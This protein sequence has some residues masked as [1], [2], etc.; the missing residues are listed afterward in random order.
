MY[1]VSVARSL[2]KIEASDKDPCSSVFQMDGFI[3]D[4][5]YVAKKITMVLYINGM[6]YPW[7]AISTQENYGIKDYYFIF[8]VYFSTLS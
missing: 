3:S 5:N 4:S 6:N 8:S 7:N 2:M 1:G